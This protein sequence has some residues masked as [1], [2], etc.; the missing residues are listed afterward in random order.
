MQAE[1]NGLTGLHQ[2]RESTATA[3]GAEAAPAASPPRAAPSTSS[4]DGDYQYDTDPGQAVQSQPAPPDSPV[5]PRG[6]GLRRACMPCACLLGIGKVQRRLQRPGR[7][8]NMLAGHGSP[9]ASVVALS[10]PAHDR[11]THYLQR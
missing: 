7:L 6:D 3:S 11:S 1:L 5:R 2:M 10:F 4:L 9:G 8:H